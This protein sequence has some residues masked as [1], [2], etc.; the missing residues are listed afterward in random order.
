MDD[1]ISIWSS[2]DL[3]KPFPYKD[4]NKLRAEFLPEE[5]FFN[6]D[7]NSY[8]MNI[9]GTLSYILEGKS[10]EIPPEQIDM[11]RYSFFDLF[12]E[13]KFL[14]DKVSGY[15]DFVQNYRNFEEARQ[16]LLMYLSK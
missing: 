14:E 3:N 15:H 13:Y 12:S 4:T 6:C 16:M 10:V 8:C 1:M 5:D 7:F 9:A 11:L 2:L